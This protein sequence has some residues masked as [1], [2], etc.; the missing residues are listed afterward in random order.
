MFSSA[1]MLPKLC[2]KESQCVYPSAPL[3][4]MLSKC[5]QELRSINALTGTLRDQSIPGQLALGPS[6]QYNQLYFPPVIAITYLHT[7]YTGS[8]LSSLDLK[9]SACS[10]LEGRYFHSTWCCPTCVQFSIAFSPP[11]SYLHAT[12]NS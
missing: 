10:P 9:L 6:Y 12:K 11:T 2:T 8:Y 3:K 5:A 4:H 7:I 1:H